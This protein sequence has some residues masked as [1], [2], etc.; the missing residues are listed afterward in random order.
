MSGV[1]ISMLTV[2]SKS[3]GYDNTVLS[4]IATLQKGVLHL[5]VYKITNKINK[6]V[7]IGQTIRDPNQRFLR[8]LS[9]ALHDVLDTYFARA[10]R[11]YGK[12]NFELEIID[13]AE[14]REELTQKELYWISF[15][16]SC[17]KNKGYNCSPG[18]YPCG[19]NTY[20]GI[21][22]VM[23][24][25]IKN[26]L[27]KSKKGGKNP[28]SKKVSA[29]DVLSGEVLL[30]ESMQEASEYFE[31]SSHMPISRRARNVTC[32]LLNDRYL[33]EYC[34]EESVTTTESAACLQQ[35]G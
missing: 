33:I 4:L 29:T 11:K 30:F 25:K 24:T 7:Y 20:A 28:N 13:T 26:K 1:L 27:S 8:H 19:G 14:T 5:Y 31:L 34:S 35:V 2:K 32:S 21:D 12:D 23:L 9:D 18:G 16:D 15:Y 10:I 3:I 22:E 6:K 17:N